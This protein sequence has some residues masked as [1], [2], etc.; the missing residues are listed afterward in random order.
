VSRSPVHSILLA[1]VVALLTSSVLAS[2]ALATVTA[3]QIT[4]PSDPTLLPLLERP[5][6]KN[7]TQTLTV[8]GT[9]TTDDGN[10]AD[11]VELQ[12]F[13]TSSSGTQSETTVESLEGTPVQLAVHP[14][15]TFT[16][17]DLTGSAQASLESLWR[18][19][20]C[21]LRAVPQGTASSAN[22][23]AF[24]GP[25][26][27]DA[28]I[29]F[30]GG[31]EAQPSD[32][33]LSTSTL[34][35][36]WGWDTA[37]SCGPYGKVYSPETFQTDATYVSDCEASLYGENDS[38]TAASIVVDGHNAYGTWAARQIHDGASGQTYPTPSPPVFDQ[39]TGDL[40]QTE[41]EELVRCVAGDGSPVDTLHPNST[42]CVKFVSTGV[43]LVRT[44]AT[45]QSGLQA[46]VS[47]QFESTDGASHSI[48]LSYEEEQGQGNTTPSYRFPGEAAFSELAEGSTAPHVTSAP[49]TIYFQA[50]HLAA[51]P[52]NGIQNPRGAITVATA[53]DS[54]HVA[55]D[56]QLELNYTGRTVP[57]TGS[58]ELVQALSQALTQTQIETLGAHAEE[59]LAGPALAIASPASGTS[60]STPTVE[61]SGTSSSGVGISSVSV[62]GV[63]APVADNGTW[64]ATVPLST[65]AN[66]L[67]ALATDALGRTASRAI[68]VT[69]APSPPSPS[70][71]P[72]APLG[73]AQVGGLASSHGKVSFTLACVGAAGGKCIVHASLTTVERL[74]GHRLLGLTARRRI[75]TRRVTIARLTLTLTVDQRV[76]V[77]LT[78]NSAGRKLLARFGGLPAH[79]TVTSSP[80]AGV[81]ASTV[82]SRNLSIKAVKKKR[83][84]RH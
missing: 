73:I 42:T 12:C 60:V 65:G 62:N 38:R 40:S 30:Y 35:G 21:T 70:Q 83:K 18:E 77:T 10:A 68:A 49:E 34:Q 72:A 78:L 41:A 22:V 47:D 81:K 74:R 9:T 63:S 57:A 14:D 7:S 36:Y 17:A 50:N 56:K 5:F 26:L 6:A 51:E 20:P 67:T 45:G 69:Y 37:S 52:E 59:Q 54:I 23:D 84:P 66:T 8:A 28:G 39:S 19:Q 55:N 25:R 27:G 44:V 53:P 31:T 33:Y 2:S 46:R 61:V 13:Y 80:G 16:T 48:S 82:L 1:V 32:D 4:T 29:T 3:S 76:R 15:G 64:S 71:P 58:F 24:A 75:H 11:A 43:K 79:L